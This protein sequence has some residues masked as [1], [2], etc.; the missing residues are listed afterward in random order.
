VTIIPVSGHPDNALELLNDVLPP[1]CG[2][3]REGGVE[4]VFGIFPSTNTFKCFSFGI[5][6]SQ[7]YTLASSTDENIKKCT[8]SF[9]GDN[10][11][12]T[13]FKVYRDIYCLLKSALASRTMRVRLRE[14][15]GGGVLVFV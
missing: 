9:I 1:L 8:G 14:R 4:K 7:D 5:V 3:S 10:Q 13:A 15:K 12:F 2:R 6:Y 11:C